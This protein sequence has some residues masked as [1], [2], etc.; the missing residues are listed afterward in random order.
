MYSFFFHKIK[1]YDFFKLY[2]VCIVVNALIKITKA[3]KCQVL[4][5]LKLNS[6]KHFSI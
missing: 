5:I 1:K 6:T 3:V 2:T 4:K